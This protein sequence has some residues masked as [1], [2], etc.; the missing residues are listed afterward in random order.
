MTQAIHPPVFVSGNAAREVFRWEDAIRALQK[1]YSLPLR[2]AATPPRTIARAEGT[3]LRTLP[4]IPP[5]SRFYGAKLMG[6]AARSSTPGVEYVVVLYDHETSRIAAFVDANQI[7]GFR[8]A[9]TSAAAL[10]RLAPHRPARLAV[11]GSGL[12]ASMHARAFAAVREFS[13]VVVFSPSEDR[14]HAF[15]EAV[16]QDLAVPARTAASAEEAVEGAD[17]VLGA[18]RSR[19]E[20][21]ILYGNWLKSGSLVMSIGSTVPEQREIDIS[22]V[23]RSDLIVGDMLEE[24]LEQTG[25]MIA[26][27]HAGIDFHHKAISLADLMSG[28]HD[29]RVKAASAPLFKSV[30]GGLQDVVVA[31]LILTKALEAGLA[32]PLPVAFETKH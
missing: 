3:W 6:M 4:A 25:D 12:E 24:V 11:L 1:T 17:I 22:V 21:P 30:G 27:S 16:T 14:R 31:E 26:A 5:G 9:A 2:A 28:V 15:A 13:E 29:E 19:D 10:D 8:T 23:E 20:Q 32:T 18:A 7:T